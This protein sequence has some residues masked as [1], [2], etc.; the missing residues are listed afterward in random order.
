MPLF[1]YVC[2]DCGHRFESL[3]RNTEEKVECPVC[4]SEKTERQIGRP[5]VQMGNPYIP[6]I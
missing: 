4:K 6:K 1:D 3:V 2:Q 5:S